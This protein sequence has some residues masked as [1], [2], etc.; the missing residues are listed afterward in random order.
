MQIFD[1]LAGTKSHAG[2]LEIRFRAGT[3][4][5]QLPVYYFSFCTGK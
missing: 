4:I 1:Q 2:M 5:I 3:K